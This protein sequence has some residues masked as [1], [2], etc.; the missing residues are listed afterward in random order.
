VLVLHITRMRKVSSLVITAAAMSA[1]VLAAFMYGAAHRAQI[2]AFAG[3]YMNDHFEHWDHSVFRWFFYYS[4]YGRVFE[5]ILGCLTAQIYGLLAERPV[6]AYEAR[7]G[8]YLLSASLIYL[9]AFAY[10]YMFEPFGPTVAEYVELLKL[11]FGCAI[12]IAVLIFCVS[13]YRSSA[14]AAILSAPLMVMLG[15][16]SYSI[17]TVHTWTLRIFERPTMTFSIGVGL[18]AVFRIILALFF[19]VILSTATYSLI[20][21]PARAWVRK[22]VARHLLRRYGTREANRISQEQV[23]STRRE[24]AVLSAFVA[25]LVAV[26]LYQFLIVPYFAPYTR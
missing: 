2:A 13:R 10:L 23:Y 6:S 9:L 7:A 4:P 1:V 11:N 15:D 19:T 17:Y 5:F 14:V 12:P 26:V 21:V 16:L 18:E 8:R 3:Q 20:E 22:L 25:M 24:I